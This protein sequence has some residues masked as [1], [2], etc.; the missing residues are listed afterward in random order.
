MGYLTEN[1]QLEQVFSNIRKLLK[2]GGIFL[3]DGW[4]GPA[5]LSQRPE[6]RVHSYDVNE[7]HHVLRLVTP[8]LDSLHQVVNIHYRVLEIKEDQVLNDTS[9]THQMRYFF[10]M[11]TRYFIEK[12]GFYN[13]GLYPFGDLE[14]D[15]TL[16]DWNMLVAAR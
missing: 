15:L 2:I 16:N 3:F 4:Y 6:S 14:R 1:K 13:V 10:P 11:E 7:N 5:V 8:E 12:A 9:E